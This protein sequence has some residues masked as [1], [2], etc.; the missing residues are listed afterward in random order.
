MIV[1][2]EDSGHRAMSEAATKQSC[3]YDQTE[4]GQKMK[5]RAGLP[6][7]RNKRVVPP[8]DVALQKTT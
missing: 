1:E 7:K 6:A 4:H 5:G 2:A 3:E 8:A